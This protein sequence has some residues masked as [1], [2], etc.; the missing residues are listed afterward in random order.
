MEKY[1]LTHSIRLDEIGHQKMNKVKETVL[2]NFYK[3][4]LMDGR[5]H[6]LDGDPLII[7]RGHNRYIG[8]T[9]E[10]YTNGDS[11]EILYCFINAVE[12]LKNED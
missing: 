1:T 11:D 8:F 2:S 4:L 10:G 5:Y 12:D 7:A 3:R 6:E 9:I